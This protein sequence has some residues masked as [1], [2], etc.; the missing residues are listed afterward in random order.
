MNDLSNLNEDHPL[1]LF[2]AM[3]RSPESLRQ[4]PG[5]LQPFFNF[6]NIQENSLKDQAL[7]FVQ[8]YKNDND[9]ERNLQ[10]QLIMFARYQ[11]T[12]VDKKEIS[13][14]TVPN[15]FKAI[16]LFCQA[17]NLS[18]KV[19]WK[20]ISKGIPL[21]LKASDDRA[22]T[23]EEIQKL[24]EFPDRRIKPLVLTLVSSGI[25]IGAFE[26]LKWKHITPIYDSNNNDVIS[27]KIV[28]YPGDREQYYS[29]L[30]PE[31]YTAL[32]EWLDYRS[33]CGENIT[34]NSI[35]M[36]D[37]WQEDDKEGA[38]N[39]KPLNSFAITRLLNRAWQ[40]QKIRQ[41]LQKGEKRHEFKTAHGFRK[42]FKTQAEQSRMHSAKIEILMGHSLGV[43]DSYIRFTEDQLLE[44]YLA[45]VEYLTI[46]QNVV[47]INRSIKKQ[48][49]Y[50]QKS[51]KEMEERHRKE[52]NAVH[53]KYESQINS[54][55]TELT[56]QKGKITEILNQQHEDLNNM[57]KMMTKFT[58][59]IINK[60]N[61]LSSYTGTSVSSNPI[62]FKPLQKIIDD[63]PE[64]K[65]LIE[66]FLSR[67][68]L[69]IP[70]IDED[71]NQVKE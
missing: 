48:S 62:W 47:L 44:E 36:R 21:G 15:Y 9:V 71:T 28:V 55:G 38:A 13:P 39:P 31:A 69:K 16:K 60:I 22:P 61:S 45:V 3:L 8:K 56:E 37:I 20:I 23:L 65:E 42:Y 27:A 5:R 54:L 59:S 18:N 4:Y 12:R 33:A 70:S 32:N 58:K 40:S 41:K 35:V 68:D 43:S 50:M 7:A 10:K 6:L 26:T 63:N 1:S 19:E 49:E 67:F 51:L 66:E 25:R 53:E 17:N 14:T 52:I 11:K 64:Q 29:F 46:N 24:L 57:D 2:L 34:G 30:T